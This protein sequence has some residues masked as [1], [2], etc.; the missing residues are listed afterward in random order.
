MRGGKRGILVSS[1]R[2]LCAKPQFGIARLLG[3]ANR[4]WAFHPAIKADCKTKKRGGGRR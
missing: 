3:H 2:N 4:G 1:A